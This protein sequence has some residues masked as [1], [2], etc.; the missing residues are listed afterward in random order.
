MSGGT[1]RPHS[2]TTQLCFKAGICG[3]AER[4]AVDYEHGHAIEERSEGGAN[5]GGNHRF[6]KVDCCFRL[7]SC[8]RSFTFLWAQERDGLRVCGTT[9]KME[10]GDE[11]YRTNR[12]WRWNKTIGVVGRFFLIA[13][14]FYHTLLLQH[15]IWRYE[16]L[17]SHKTRHSLQPLLGIP[18]HTPHHTHCSISTRRRDHNPSSLFTKP[19]NM[20][21]CNSRLFVFLLLFLLVGAGLEWLTCVE[22]SFATT[23]LENPIRRALCCFW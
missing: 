22:F 18:I 17:L 3:M 15:K 11:G 1:Q 14:G 2:I 5:H 16:H 12:L 9:L 19:T 7:S 23:V 6:V 4:I 8:C 20:N 21:V 13:H 10:R